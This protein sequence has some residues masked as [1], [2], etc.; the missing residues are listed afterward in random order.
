MTYP[1]ILSKIKI[2]YLSM[3]SFNRFNMLND[4]AYYIEQLKNNSSLK[5]INYNSCNGCFNFDL[6]EKLYFYKTGEFTYVPT[7]KGMW[8][9]CVYKAYHGMPRPYFQEQ[10][11]NL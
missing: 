7:Y 3:D 10:N 6:I 4:I 8:F 9:L 11:Y 5:F 1:N 2:H